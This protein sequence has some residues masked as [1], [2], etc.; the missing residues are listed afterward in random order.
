MCHFEASQSYIKPLFMKVQPD[1]QLGVLLIHAAHLCCSYVLPIHAA[2]F[3]VICMGKTN[4]AHSCCP[5][6]LPINMPASQSCLNAGHSCRCPVSAS[7][8]R[9]TYCSHQLLLHVA[10]SCCCPVS[11]NAKE[12]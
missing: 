11:L 2:A 8:S 5:F 7:Q 9:I 3:A 1:M 10:H 12:A 4:A 6:M